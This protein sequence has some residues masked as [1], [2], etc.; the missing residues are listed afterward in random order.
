MPVP[1]THPP[2]HPRVYFQALSFSKCEDDFL[3]RRDAS[4]DVSEMLLHTSVLMGGRLA[5]QRRAGQKEKGANEM[6]AALSCLSSP[7]PSM[8]FSLYSVGVSAISV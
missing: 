1:L 7:P 5:A 3:I 8:L 2:P 4:E 6:C